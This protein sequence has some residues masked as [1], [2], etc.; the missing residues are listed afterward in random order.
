TW[1]SPTRPMASRRWARAASRWGGCGAGAMDP[2]YL[3]RPFLLHR[4]LVPACR[5]QRL[6]LDQAPALER[7]GGE[8]QL[9]LGHGDQAA[10][11]LGGAGELPRRQE[12]ARA[13]LDNLGLGLLAVDENR[14]IEQIVLGQIVLVVNHT[15]E[16]LAQHVH[17]LLGNLR[18]AVLQALPLGHAQEA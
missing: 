7:E 13:D 12:E 11:L 15:A 9:A 10:R 3:E 2:P 16:G 8:C 6:L 4:D 5:H 1:L 17:G 18:I 14:C